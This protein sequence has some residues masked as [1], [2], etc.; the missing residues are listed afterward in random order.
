MN[1]L[2]QNLIFLNL[3]SLCF[4]SFAFVYIESFP[5]TLSVC[6]TAGI[7]L[8]GIIEVVS[9][10]MRFKIKFVQFMLIC[11]LILALLIGLVSATILRFEIN[12]TSNTLYIF[13]IV[14]FLMSAYQIDDVSFLKK[15][16]RVAW[17]YT[18]CSAYGIY[19]FI[20]YI[21]NLPL[22]NITWTNHM[23]TGFNTTNMIIIGGT[24]HNRVNSIFLEPSF[25]SKYAA[26]AILILL[27]LYKDR[28]IQK[29]N[30]II[31]VSINTMALVFSVSGTGILLL[32]VCGCIYIINLVKN[33]L[34]IKSR[35]RLLMIVFA[36]LMVIWF[37]YSFT[38]EWF[39][40]MIS[41]TQE[42][43]DPSKSGG[44]RF[45]VP[46]YIMFYSF[47]THFFGVGAGNEYYAIRQYSQDFN[48]GLSFSTLSSGYAKIGCELGLLGLIAF[49]GL[50]F[51]MKKRDS[52]FF[53]LFVVLVM[54]NFLGGT[55]LQTDFWAWMF[56]LNSRRHSDYMLR[57]A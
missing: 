57:T 15:L 6:L 46:Y 43:F 3:I 20:A 5:V 9:Y 30:M 31:F 2:K 21:F 27:I 47:L 16:K 23:V 44:I 29:R 14:S 48:I 36:V 41:R 49:V 12:Y 28:V 11:T 50:I 25:L 8:I 38:N 7:L 13:Y 39:T 56:L 53:Y 40:Y 54:L 37:L 1:K 26:I 4:N 45:T 32:T 55:L 24:S 22:Q 35:N 17:A 10:G 33:S 18:L 51:S 52:K 19:Q 42:I 34:D